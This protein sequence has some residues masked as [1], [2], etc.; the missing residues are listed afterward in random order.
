[1]H[2]QSGGRRAEVRAVEW[3]AS[4]AFVPRL[5]QVPL[6]R[7]VTALGVK[8]NLRSI[9]RLAAVDVEVHALV[10]RRGDPGIVSIALVAASAYI[11]VLSSTVP[12]RGHLSDREFSTCSSQLCKRCL[13]AKRAVCHVRMP[14][15]SDPALAKS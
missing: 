7:D 13:Q 10:G 2:H 4:S 9:R 3:N 11:P 12:Q 8:P 15:N 14:W 5:S 6:A 1:M